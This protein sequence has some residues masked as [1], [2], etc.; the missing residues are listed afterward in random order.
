MTSENRIV[1]K[2][3]L[4]AGLWFI[5][6][7]LTVPIG[8]DIVFFFRDLINEAFNTDQGY[9]Y[10][11]VIAAVGIGII[12]M[13]TF[14]RFITEKTVKGKGNWV[15]L[16]SVAGIYTW[17]LITMDV[18]T[19]R[20]HFLEY[21]LLIWLL[22]R[23]FTQN[24][25]SKAVFACSGFTGIF[26]G[27][28][29]EWFQ[30]ILPNRTGEFIDIIWNT[31][32]VCLP[33][34]I[35]IIR[36]RE[37]QYSAPNE[38]DLMCVR[39]TGCLAIAGIA[40]FLLFTQQF[41]IQVL[42]RDGY[43]F[44]TRLDSPEN[45]IQNQNE[46]TPSQSEIINIETNLSYDLFLK[47]YNEIDF[48]AFNEFRVHLFRRN[49]YLG[50]YNHYQMRNVISD[51]DPNVTPTDIWPDQTSR[52]YGMSYV[53]HYLKI[54]LNENVD[55]DHRNNPTFLSDY[56]RWLD[57]DFTVWGTSLW[58]DYVAKQRAK[59]S[60]KS[61]ESKL[62]KNLWIAK[63]E[64]RI[65]ENYFPHLLQLSGQSWR[66]EF[67]DDVHL[68]LLNYSPK[69]QYI[70]SVAK[71]IVTSFSRKEI[72]I[73]SSLLILL[74]LATPK[75][76]IES[77]KQS[78][79]LIFSTIFYL[80]IVHPIIWHPPV[81]FAGDNYGLS[82]NE[83]VIQKTSQPPKIDGVNAELEWPVT[84]TLLKINTGT[85]PIDTG[86]RISG[87]FDDQNFY[88][89]IISEDKDIFSS[90]TTRDG[91]LWRED[92]VEIFID[93]AG[94]GK[95][96]FEI[97]INPVNTIYDALI[98]FSHS[99]DFNESKKINIASVQTMTEVTDTSWVTE[100]MIPFAALGITKTHFFSHS[101]INI[102]RINALSLDPATYEYSALSPTNGWFHKPRRFVKIKKDS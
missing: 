67:K 4:W 28:C 89:I 48:P 26:L 55:P 77:P 60:K 50:Y 62:N 87:T 11:G 37:K 75:L 43:T 25:D 68:I 45:L 57:G 82:P 14:Y 35:L 9:A 41:G 18:P 2:P 33:L 23:A 92:A 81:N 88:L 80:W 27:T 38:R 97:E 12:L 19:E 7:F 46:I 22:V 64:N 59:S 1:L 66:P 85:F 10:V 101:R 83:L 102:T 65:L 79:V 40:G 69:S 8:P 94:D 90:I 6:T 76:L 13:T 86:T 91:E 78:V 70:S 5:A 51:H 72:L 36:N 63:A 84:S 54:W 15:V 98:P 47:N 31:L 32:A 95:N 16:M 56:R 100:I 73:I 49:R 71:S 42:D 34:I 39:V 3:F 74:L 99:I 21:G 24:L 52:Y 58:K 17:L 93:T 96:Y 30:H 53:G 29:D 20:I 44:Y 61:S